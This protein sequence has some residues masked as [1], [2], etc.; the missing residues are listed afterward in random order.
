MN[1]ALGCKTSEVALTLLTQVLQIEN[2]HCVADGG[3][4]LMNATAMIAELEPKTATEALLAVQ[5]VGVQRLAMLCLRRAALDGQ[6]PEGIDANVL[7]ASRLMRVFIEQLEAM[8]KLKG[9]AGQ[10]RVVVE[11]VTVNQGGQ[12]IVG[13]VNASEP[14]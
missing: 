9:K 13:A 12:A 1:A 8:A 5:M 4:L 2:P 3:A 10:Q 14:D 11:H 6:T 7:R